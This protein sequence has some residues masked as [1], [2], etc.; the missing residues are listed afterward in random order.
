MKTVFVGLM[1]FVGMHIWATY[2]FV[3]YEQR[4][5]D[6]V[7][8]ASIARDSRDQ[9]LSKGRWIRTFDAKTGMSTYRFAARGEQR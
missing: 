9:L 1:M 7:V 8:E 5:A 4:L 6:A 3:Q 2:R